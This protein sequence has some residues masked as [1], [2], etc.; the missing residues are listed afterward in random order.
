[1]QLS[2][3]E[4]GLQAQC[5]SER[6][7]GLVKPPDFTQRDAEILCQHRIVRHELRGSPRIR[8]T[9]LEFTAAECVG[10]QKRQRRRVIRR[11]FEQRA[12][13]RGSSVHVTARGKHRGL[14]GQ[15]RLM[16]GGPAHSKRI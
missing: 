10:A 2:R 9:L 14:P 13:H 6:L 7:A 11:L 12:V 4:I 16:T 1:M 15:F 3:G 5:P 8:R